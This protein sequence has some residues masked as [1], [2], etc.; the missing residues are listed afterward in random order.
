MDRRCGFGKRVMCGQ[1]AGFLEE[2]MKA[3]VL[4][5]KVNMGVCL[6][7]LAFFLSAIPALFLSAPFVEDA[8]GT[9]GAAAFLTGHDWGDFLVDKGFYYKYGQS[10]FY[11][12]V[13][14]CVHNPVVRYK[15]LL[16][17]NSA[18]MAFVPVLAYRIGERHFALP[19]SDAA[20]IALIS[21][22]MPAALLYGKLTWAEPVLFLIP[23][24]ILYM[25]LELESVRNGAGATGRKR[26]LS[27]LLAWGCAFAFMS[28]QR[29]IIVVL[30]TVLFL[31]IWAVKRKKV[32]VSWPVFGANLVAALILDRVLD[33]WLKLY[34]YQ[35]AELKHNT[36]SAF[37]HI[38]IYRKLFSP[39]GLKVVARTVLGWLFNSSVSGVGI[40]LLGIVISF[41]CVF[42]YKK[43]RETFSD[44]FRILCLVG[45]ILYIGAF[46]L[47]MLFFFETLY[48]YWMGTTVDRCD[49]LVFGRYLESTLPVMLFAGLYVL[50]RISFVGRAERKGESVDKVDDKHEDRNARDGAE[51]VEQYND[52]NAWVGKDD[53]NV[54]RFLLRTAGAVFVL[55]IFLS[56]FFAVEISLDMKGIDCYVHSLMSMNVCFDM[57]NV[58]L[59]QDIISNLGIAIIIYAI[60]CCILFPLF[61]QFA[62][63]GKIKVVY[64]LTGILFIYIYLRSFCDI[65]YRVDVNALTDYAKYYLAH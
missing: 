65:L 15:A 51:T 14:F 7:V 5:R 41:A 25:L 45:G 37:L 56:V 61:V 46:L 38:E 31:I 16:L 23:W 62:K 48:D 59:T 13:F 42:G 57:T 8:L 4:G 11:L 29:G 27:A 26:L 28:H 44:K 24:G 22:C 2:G 49:H 47:G 1:E 36:L 58:S 3:G 55:M 10:L 6:Y 33:V 32:L 12:P 17:V 52:R 39:L 35:G 50:E 18:L 19:S 21:G 63:K 60:I 53:A 9:M 64:L 43:M 34:V 20:F 54:A 30:A 40:S